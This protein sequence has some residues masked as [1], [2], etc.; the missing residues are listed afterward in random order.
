ML[1]KHNI[2]KLKEDVGLQFSE[3]TLWIVPYLLLR[4]RSKIMNYRCID[5]TENIC[6]I[7]VDYSDNSFKKLDVIKYLNSEWVKKKFN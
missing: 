7:I 4:Q 6:K 3:K 2:L 5:V 1:L